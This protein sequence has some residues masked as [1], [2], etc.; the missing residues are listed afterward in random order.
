MLR[1]CGADDNLTENL[2]MLL[3]LLGNK[4]NASLPLLLAL[5]FC[6]VQVNAPKLCFPLI[7]L[8]CACVVPSVTGN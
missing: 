1:N 6:F 4:C 2:R 5:H 8:V 3:T 7:C